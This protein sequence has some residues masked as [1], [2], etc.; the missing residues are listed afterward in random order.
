MTVDLLGMD[1]DAL[2]AYCAALGEKPFRAKQLMRWIHQAG[3]DD[4]GAMTD[5]SKRFRETLAKTA[6]VG[7][8][9]VQRDT[10]AADGT[11][12]WLLDVGT[13]NAIETVFIPEADRGTLCVSSQ[14]GCAL[15]CSFCSTARAS[16]ATSRSAKSSASCGGPRARC[17]RATV[18]RRGCGLVTMAQTATV[19]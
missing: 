15:E 19:P 18:R 3:V 11:R 10:T 17:G 5:M 8:P 13:G 6:T 2:R 12:K 7:A 9:R 1:Q 4:F 16:I 14:A